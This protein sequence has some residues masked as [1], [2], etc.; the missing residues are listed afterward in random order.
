MLPCDVIQ[1]AASNLSRRGGKGEKERKKKGGKKMQRLWQGATQRGLGNTTETGKWR[2][3]AL[4][5]AKTIKQRHKI[6]LLYFLYALFQQASEDVNPKTF[7]ALYFLLKC[8]V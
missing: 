2:I 3:A 4:P 5:L 1:E 7:S 8:L 6:T